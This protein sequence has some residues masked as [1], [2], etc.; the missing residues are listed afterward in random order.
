MRSAPSRRFPLVALVAVLVLAGCRTGS[1]LHDRYNNFRAYYNAYYNASR[2]MEEGESQLERPDQ[3]IDRTRLI[4]IFPSG[5]SGRGGQ[6][7]EA[8]EKSSE[9][10]RARSSSKWADDALF[11]IGKAYFYQGNV[12]GAEQ[13]FQETITVAQSRGNDR[14]ADEARLW[15]GRTLAQARRYDEGAEILQARLAEAG[16]ERGADV[17]RLQLVLA[18]LYAREGRYD[19]A[20][21]LLRRNAANERDDDVAARA[22]ILLGQVEEQREQFDAAAL[23]YRDAAARRPAYELEYA[24]TLS[25]ALI[26]GLDAERDRSEEALDLIR[27]M[28]RD[29]KNYDHRAEVELAYGRILAATGNEREGLEA[30]RSLLYDPQLQGGSLRGETHTRLAEF[31]RD[32][33]GDFVRAAAHFDT[34]ATA[35]RAPPSPDEAPTRAAILNMGRTSGAFNAYAAVASRL[36]E[37]DS[38][39]ELGMLDEDSFAARIEAIEAR[40]LEEYRE[41]QRRLERTQTRQEFAGGGDGMFRDSNTP[42]GSVS[43]GEAGQGGREVGFLS[44]RDNASVQAN[45]LTFQRI[46]GDRPLVPGW[47]RQSAI[48]ASAVASEV[49]G[50]AQA[51]TF[52]QRF[53]GDGPQRLDL[54][55][56]PRTPAAQILLRSERASLRYEAANALF[57]S[58]AR[59]DSAATLYRLALEDNGPPEVALRIRFALAEVETSL[60]RDAEA[61]ALYG[62]IVEEAPESEL[63]A[64]ARIRLGMEPA[65]EEATD[66]TPTSQPYDRARERWLEGNYATAVTDF[67][68][69]AADTS[70]A[71]DAPRALLAAAAAYVDWARRDSLDLLAPLP[72]SV[73]P[74]GLFPDPTDLPEPPQN[75]PPGQPGALSLEPP[76][77]QDPAQ[78]DPAQPP[79]QPAVRPLDDTES[80]DMPPAREVDLS[81]EPQPSAQPPGQ[82]SPPVAVQPGTERAGGDPAGGD[83]TGEDPTGENVTP[84]EVSP[85]IGAAPEE[86]LG[87]P[88]AGSPNRQP[89]LA[90]PLPI[91]ETALA[92]SPAPLDTLDLPVAEPAPTLDPVPQPTPEPQGP[93]VDDVLALVVSKAPRTPYARR[94]TALRARLAP[95]PA[96]GAE[97]PEP[98]QASPEQYGMEGALPIDASFGGFTWR[99]QRAPTA[100]AVSVVLNRYLNQGIRAAAI[101]DTEGFRIIIGQFES[102]PDA[103]AARDSLPEEARTNASIVPLSGIEVLQL[104]NV[105]QL[106]E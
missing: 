101:R 3:A 40:R 43:G 2:V 34:A 47:R 104:E 36:A 1:P 65:T 38:L 76:D 87:E 5:A 75:A 8:I 23:A 30:M 97:E 55:P 45:L 6:F 66:V 35:L 105:E 69:L 70:R 99:T 93:T 54:T 67:L 37:K 25:R 7:Q 59:P 78:Q 39:L 102:R 41:E 94:A 80:F 19:E 32:V 60:G 24:A 74:G 91:G 15:L 61:T 56:I 82:P 71:E 103:F 96:G 13:K 57:L 22:F 46:W 50:G 44:V 29:D 53:A 58:L 86:T 92:P 28:R 12:V 16:N 77:Q 52:A 31:Y 83:P 73:L 18:E 17:T 27:R 48:D 81:G 95:E 9:L 10:L 89:G 64:A 14:L 85:R 4:A 26:L 90:P 63:A 11:I 42:G 84:R 79:A 88:A 100:L 98:Q 68:A 33:R 72:E 20:A 62:E 106:S 49:A 21:E 51:S